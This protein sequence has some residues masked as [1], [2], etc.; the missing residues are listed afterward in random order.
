[1][2]KIEIRDHKSHHMY[3]K[4]IVSWKYIF[5]TLVIL[6]CQNLRKSLNRFFKLSYIQDKPTKAITISFT[7]ARIR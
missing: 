3:Y 5:V 7:G 1:M 6:F 4:F 2:S